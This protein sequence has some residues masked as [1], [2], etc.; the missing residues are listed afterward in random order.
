MISWWTDG[1][2]ETTI[3]KMSLTRNDEVKAPVVSLYS[4][5]R[6]LVISRDTTLPTMQLTLVIRLT[7]LAMPQQSGSKRFIR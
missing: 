6:S 4:D 1:S 3:P 7:F 2:R 5:R